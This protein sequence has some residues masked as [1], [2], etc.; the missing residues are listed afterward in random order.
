MQ[1]AAASDARLAAPDALRGLALLLIACVNAWLILAPAQPEAWAAPAWSAGLD[2]HVLRVLFVGKGLALFAFLFG[3]GFAV[4]L[5]RGVTASRYARRMAVLAAIGVLHGALIWHG[6]ILLPYAVL[7]L[8]LLGFREAPVRLI[9]AAALL[10]LAVPVI[11]WALLAAAAALEILGGDVLAAVE[12]APAGLLGHYARILAYGWTILG[13]ML[14]GLAAARTNLF[15]DAVPGWRAWRT[16]AVLGALLGIPFSVLYS[17][18]SGPAAH[19]STLLSAALLAASG[20]LIAALYAAAV[21]RLAPPDR[22]APYLLRMLASAGRLPLTNY[23]GQSV[24]LVTLAALGLRGGVGP[25]GAIG[26]GAAVLV[27]QIIASRAWLGWF[28][29]GPIEALWRWA[30][31]G[32]RPVM[33]RER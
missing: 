14:L 7:G 2:L 13:C 21:A 19:S 27:V 31:S 12:M 1:P 32:N 11:V 9:V 26:I 5:D 16:A 22:R 18:L 3:W 25:P 30:S 8:V 4:L 20:P 23:L 28:S 17:V 29:T 33:R 10:A 15:R 6:D 24:I